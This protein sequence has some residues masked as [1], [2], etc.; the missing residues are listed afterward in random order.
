VLVNSALSAARLLSEVAR[1]T[2]KGPGRSPVCAAP[3][4]A[5]RKLLLPRCDCPQQSTM[6]EC[7]QPTPPWR[8]AS[9][10]RAEPRAVWIALE[11]WTGITGGRALR[12]VRG[13]EGFERRSNRSIFKSG[14]SRRAETQ[15]HCA[16]TSRRAFRDPARGAAVRSPCGIRRYRL[17]SAP[18]SRSRRR[19]ILAA[20]LVDI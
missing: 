13:V 9:V 19:P 16:R 5:S 20:R 4:H 3:G 8:G 17:A 12:A 6:N 15:M 1:K 18:N 11:S 10:P 2:T 7:R 14:I